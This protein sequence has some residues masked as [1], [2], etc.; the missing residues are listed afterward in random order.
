MIRRWPLLCSLAA[1]AALT[2]AARP[3]GAQLVG[4]PL[5]PPRPSAP[6]PPVVA[7]ERPDATARD[8]V[9]ERQRLDIQA[10]VDS[11]AGAL[12]QSNPTPVPAAAPVT[13]R[14]APRIPAARPPRQPAR[15]SAQGRRRP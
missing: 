12:S 6:P 15:P 5:P 4:V 8:T 3:A 2:L 11:A 10:W 9:E 7:A 14:P 1:G 13:T